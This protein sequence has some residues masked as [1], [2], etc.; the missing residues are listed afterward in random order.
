MSANKAY[1]KGVYTAI[2]YACRILDESKDLEDARER[3]RELGEKALAALNE[4][5]EEELKARLLI[6]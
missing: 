2:V 4:S 5:L 1:L 6:A 3:V